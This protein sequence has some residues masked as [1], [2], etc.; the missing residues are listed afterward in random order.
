[1]SY[2]GLSP[3]R[4]WPSHSPRSSLPPGG[5]GNGGPRHEHRHT[6]DPWTGSCGIYQGTRFSSSWTHSARRCLLPGLHPW[7]F[8]CRAQLIFAPG[9]PSIS[10][11]A[12]R[13]FPRRV[14]GQPRY[15][16]GSGQNTYVAHVGQRKPDRPPP[17]SLGRRAV[18]PNVY[19]QRSH[20][21]RDF[22]P[23]YPSTLP[24]LIRRLE[25]HQC[26]QSLW[27]TVSLLPQ[28]PPFS[29]PTP[30]PLP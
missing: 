17:P 29:S 14:C 22:G 3:R 28:R 25:F 2:S 4:S 20:L 18:T 21:R 11:F 6:L 23:N 16:E 1:M 10:A 13:L 15:L 19:P 7:P 27:R 24:L 26:G 30:R 8:P 5:P 9:R 12:C